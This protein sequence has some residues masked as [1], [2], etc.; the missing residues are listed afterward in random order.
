MSWHYLPDLAAESSVP[1]SWDGAPSVPWRG[2]RTAERCSSEGSETA[3]FRCS[4]SGTI[5]TA[6][7]DD[8]GLALW[9]SSLRDF[10]ANPSPSPGSRQRATMSATGGPQPFASLAKSDQGLSYWRTSQACLALGMDTLDRYSET[11]P[12]SGMIRSGTAFLLRP[13]APLMRG[14]GSGYLP[15]P[16][17]SNGKT[18]HLRS[19]GRPPRSYLPPPTAA[20][21]PNEGN[22]R[23]MRRQVQAGEITRQEAHMIV[24]KD[25]FA[26]QGKLKAETF[27]TPTAHNAKEGGYPSE[28]QR[29]TPTLGAQVGGKLNP[30][31]IA[32]LMAW[33]IG[34][35][36]LKPL[37]TGRWQAWCRSHGMS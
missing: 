2:S 13:S 3:C 15:T 30:A 18:V 23:L 32:W 27:R 9:M 28:H 25:V 16:I 22:M 29:N 36:D 20:Q 19:G 7:T 35:T 31:W 26:A 12:R 24:G 37:A 8:H 10:R 4:R 14:T 17:A 34:W 11:W 21:R 6:S 1:T 33:P 5:A